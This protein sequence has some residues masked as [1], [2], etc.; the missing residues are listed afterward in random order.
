MVMR[1]NAKGPDGH[2]TTG[3]GATEV[4]AGAAFPQ[5]LTLVALLAGG[6]TSEGA[7]VPFWQTVLPPVGHRRCAGV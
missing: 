5:G 1:V 3:C 4:A 7:M 2:L 6:A